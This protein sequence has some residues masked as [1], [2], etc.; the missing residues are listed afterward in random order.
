MPSYT[1]ERATVVAAPSDVLRPLVA[2]LRA[3]QRWSPWEGLDDDLERTY[4]P[5]TA[6]DGSGVGGSYAWSGNRRAGRGRMEVVAVEPGR[7][8]VEVVFEKPFRST[9]TSE[10]LLEPTT[11]TT[12]PATRLVWRMTGE[13][14]G[15]AGVLSR[16]VPM[17]RLLGRDVERGLATLREV[18][19][20]G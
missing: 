4:G 9:S 16:V 15:L 13:Q 11:V 8:A 7:V 19:E 20:A 17:D 5:P 3:W 10:F 2:D 12:G 18:A 14:A 6:A 1:V